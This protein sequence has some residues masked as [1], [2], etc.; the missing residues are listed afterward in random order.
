MTLEIISYNTLYNFTVNVPNAVAGSYELVVTSQLSNTVLF[1][2]SLTVITTNGR[3]TEFQFTLPQLEGDNH[4]NGM[5]N[6]TVLLDTGVWDSGS[7]KLVYNPGGGT[8][9]QNYISDNEDREAI[10][11]YTPEY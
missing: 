4:F 3:Y 9:T 6:Y 7:L 2:E 5:Y 8:G 1:Q 11:Y 10:V